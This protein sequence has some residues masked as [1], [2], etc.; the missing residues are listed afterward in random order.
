MTT[1]KI[2]KKLKFEDIKRAINGEPMLFIDKA[3][4][5]NFIDNELALIAKKNTKAKDP[6]K[7]SAKQVEN[8]GYKDSIM[9]Y[10]ESR[11]CP[12]TCSE[13]HEKI[14]ELANMTVQK[15]VSLVCSLAKENKVVKQVEN[16]TVFW[17]IVTE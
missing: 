6:A 1:N 4:A 12:V 3:E 9:A 16:N 8:N 13:L 7:P 17:A 11:G 15:T 14:P 5:I 2:T 10:M